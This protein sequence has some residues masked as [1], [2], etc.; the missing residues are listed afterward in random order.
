MD[1]RRDDSKQ[2]I[3]TSYRSLHSHAVHIRTLAFASEHEPVSDIRR[4]PQPIIQPVGFPGGPSCE[5][6]IN[7]IALTIR[8]CCHLI[9]P[10]WLQQRLHREQSPPHSQAEQ[11]VLL[12][13]SNQKH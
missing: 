5:S 8:N 7:C 2:L 6:S 1:R 4:I 11:Y 10:T 13:R 9:L 12:L 3:E